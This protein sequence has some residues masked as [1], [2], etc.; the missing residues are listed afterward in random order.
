[1]SGICKANQ[2]QGTK[3]S[4]IYKHYRDSN[5]REHNKIRKMVQELIDALEAARA[6]IAKAQGAA[7]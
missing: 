5:R 6:A 3:H 2:R 1:M 4:G 7:K